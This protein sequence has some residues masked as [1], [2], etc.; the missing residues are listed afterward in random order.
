M[1]FEV[2]K[3]RPPPPSPTPLDFPAYDTASITGNERAAPFEDLYDLLLSIRRPQDLSVDHLKALNLDILAAV[4]VSSLVPEEYMRSLPPLPWEDNTRVNV[5]E[6]PEARQNTMGNGTPYPPED[7]FDLVKKE[8]LLDNQDAFREVTR[9]TPLPGRQRVRI[10]QSR[11]FWMGLER[12]AQYWDTNSDSYFRRPS[13]KVESSN[14]QAA[15]NPSADDEQVP[16]KND[17]GSDGKMEIDQDSRS[18]TPHIGEKKHSVAM[19]TGRRIGTGRDMPE[20]IRDETVRGFI[21]MAAWPFGCQVTVPILPPRL[22]VRNLL[23]PVR[24]SFLAGRNPKDRQ[25]AR[26]GIMEGPLLVVQCRPETSFRESSEAAGCGQ[27]EACDLFR[28]VGAMLLTAQERAR[29]GS[30][31]IKPGEGKWWTTKPRWGGAL[32]EGFTGE[33]GNLNG[34]PKPEAGNVSKR[35]KFEHSFLPARRAGTAHGRKLTTAEKWKILKPG[36]GLWD[37]RVQY[38]QIGKPKGNPFDDVRIDKFHLQSKL[39]V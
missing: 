28:E 14:E 22:A 38:M 16:A 21:E 10:T 8:L 25:L 12:M 33:T 29:E 15:G 37:K 34:K 1:G 17:D 31:E 6:A 7:K 27:R 24:Q 35:S 20:D 30:T 9:M 26:K 3:E 39:I 18:D 32:D 11:K 5:Q 19:Y 13:S 4:P 23:F 2:D 36:P